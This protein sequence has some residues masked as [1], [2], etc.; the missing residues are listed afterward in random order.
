[1]R[2][3]FERPQEREY[4]GNIESI[5]SD[6]TSVQQSSSS[7]CSAGTVMRC[8]LKNLQGGTPHLTMNFLESIDLILI[9]S[10][11]TISIIVWVSILI[12]KLRYWITYGNSMKC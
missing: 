8:M 2:F 11:S 5:S 6:T 7:F 3:T 10:F 4:C 12:F 1:M 9:V